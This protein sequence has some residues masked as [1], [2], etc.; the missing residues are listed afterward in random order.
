MVLD[1]SGTTRATLL[2]G[3]RHADGRVVQ[4]ALGC[5]V[6]LHLLALTIPLPRRETEL[7]PPPP[8]PPPGLVLWRHHIPPPAPAPP[9]TLQASVLPR[10]RS[11]PDPEPP[12]SQLEPVSEPVEWDS[13]PASPGEPWSLVAP[14]PPPPVP[15]QILEQDT[16]GLELPVALPGRA[17]PVYPTLA[18]RAR[19]Q[20]RVTLLAVVDIEAGGWCRSRSC[21]R[22]PPIS[23]SRRRPSRPFGPGVT[24][25]GDTGAAP[26]P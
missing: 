17:E 7:P 4:V 22:P 26:C 15:P 2:R 19:K 5:A 6:L 25:P 23:V 12:P 8:P 3:H 9:V 24:R 20:G 16:E 10:R 11:I 21:R 18:M 13:A 1:D 14:L